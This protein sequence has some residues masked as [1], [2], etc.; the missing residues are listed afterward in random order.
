MELSRVSHV[1]LHGGCELLGLSP[2]K[3]AVLEQGDAGAHQLGG[4]V[5][6]GGV[7]DD[8]GAFG[9]HEV[10]GHAL[11]PSANETGAEN[12]DGGGDGHDFEMCLIGLDGSE[13]LA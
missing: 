8:A 13:E 5:A 1:S 10:V 7:H 11:V 4:H 6:I 2:L 9:A 3:V 12:G